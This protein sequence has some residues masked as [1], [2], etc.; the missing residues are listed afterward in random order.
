MPYIVFEGPD[1]AGKSTLTKKV[2][3]R[4]GYRLVAEPFTESDNAKE[5]KKAI[6][7]NTFNKETEIFLLAANRLEAFRDV[8]TPARHATGVIGDRSVVSTMVYQ[9]ERNGTWRQLP[10]LDFMQ[11]TLQQEWHDIYPEHLFFLD[12]D[13]DTYLE[14][15]A[16]SG[17]VA[18][19]KEKAL[20]DPENWMR[21][22]EDYLSALEWIS[23]RKPEIKI[24]FITPE[25]TV[26]EIVSLIDPTV[27]VI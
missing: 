18:D 5:V 26:E 11:K 23:F 14:R 27:A 24:H 1:F 15:L 7:N 25:T 9:S 13:H 22:K 2:A 12:I 10:I 17:R 21:L 8:I 16:N 6:I 3:D 20:M 4:L 19:E